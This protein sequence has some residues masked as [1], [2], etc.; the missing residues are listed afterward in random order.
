MR[1]KRRFFILFLWLLVCMVG[2]RGG[3]VPLWGAVPAVATPV[4]Y[5]PILFDKGIDPVVSWWPNIM[6]R[7]ADPLMLGWA[8]RPRSLTEVPSAINV[9][10]PTWLYLEVDNAGLPRL[11]TVQELGRTTDF[12]GYID[13]A[14]NAGARVWV[15]AVNDFYDPDATGTL[16]RT[17]ECVDAFIEKAVSVCRQ[18]NADGLNLDFEHMNPADAQV[19]NDFAAKCTERFHEEG[20]LISADVTVPLPYPDP[21]NWWQCYDRAGLSKAVDY[22]AVMGYDQHTAGDDPGPVGGLD[23][24]EFEI[25]MSLAEIPSDKLI[26][27]VPFY[28]RD[29]QVLADGSTKVTFMFKTHVEDM[30][31]D[32]RFTRGGKVIAIAEWHVKDER[33]PDTFVNYLE[34]TDEAGTL[35]RIW[36]DDEISL[37]A[38]AALADRYH[39]AGVAVWE[40]SYGRD[41]FWEAM[42]AELPDHSD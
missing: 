2:L 32:D 9:F 24:V 16:L 10:A 29:F 31:D 26:L 35:H 4:S 22:V 33:E 27:G 19:Y 3:F 25:R 30:L 23:W 6:P 18:W 13:T 7:T 36:Y 14:H 1:R 38:R 28:S 41:S 11:R 20:L 21:D 12:T 37:A 5:E 42:A 17:P 8:Y 34:F 40:I 39:L 15:T